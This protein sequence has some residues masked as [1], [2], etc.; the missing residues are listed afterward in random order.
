[1]TP[2]LNGLILPGITRHSILEMCN[3]WAEFKTVQRS[4][5]MGEIL[6]LLKENRVSLEVELNVT[7][8]VIKPLLVLANSAGYNTRPANERSRSSIPA[9]GR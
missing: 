9:L 8:F 7:L 1:M 4:L 6:K 3:E 5:T 2:P